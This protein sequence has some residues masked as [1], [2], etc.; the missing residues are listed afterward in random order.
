MGDTSIRVGYGIYYFPSRGG[1]A[2]F[3]FGSIPP[4]SFF[5][6]RDPNQLHD[7]GGTFANPWGSNPDPFAAPISQREFSLPIQGLTDQMLTSGNLISSNG[8]C[9]CNGSC[10]RTLFLN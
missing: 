8:H 7:S 1:A 9:P 6:N 4:W 5:V 2:D 10:R 3:W